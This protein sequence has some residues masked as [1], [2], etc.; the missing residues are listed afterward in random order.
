V[1][2][3][4]LLKADAADKANTSSSQAV[5]AAAAPAAAAG[6]ASAAPQ[7]YG[8]VQYSQLEAEKQ[9]GVLRVCMHLEGIDS[10]AVES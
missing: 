1:Q 5:A 4:A 2:I 3:L 10:W 7:A 9:V 6:V 8:G